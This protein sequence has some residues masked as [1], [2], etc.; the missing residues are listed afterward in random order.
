M[1]WLYLAIVTLLAATTQSA[2]GFGFGLIAV[3]VFLLILNS[4]A[5]IQ[6]TM[7]IVL[8]MSIADWMK[9]K[10]Q[11][12]RHLLNWLVIG[13]VLGFPFGIYIFLH[14]ELHLI[15]IILALVI[16]IFSGFN[17]IR[18]FSKGSMVESHSSRQSRW[19]ITLTG[20][21]SGLLT[22][23]IAMPG[24]PV[25]LYMVHKGFDKTVIRATILTFFIF[26]Y[27]G[28]V[29][30]QLV[31]VGISTSTWMTSLSLVPVG[32]IGVICGHALALKIN[33]KLFQEIVLI[34]LI[35]MAMVILSQL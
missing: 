35:L 7:I 11:G 34:I 12:S 26:A 24:P 1:D 27:A 32:L 23:S 25:M 28:A 3:P 17:L 5:A 20:Y 2:T 14:F 18:L 22:T 30:L 8:C 29:L 16:I 6:I 21:L 31:T 9:L 4:A 15:K 33:Q 13:M 10:G 19:A